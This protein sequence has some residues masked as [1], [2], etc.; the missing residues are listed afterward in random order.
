MA[1]L[2]N[3]LKLG[4][5]GAILF[6]LVISPYSKVEESFNLQAIH[7]ILNYG[8][9]IEKYD[10]LEF[11]GVVP[12]TFIGGLLVSSLV[13]PFVKYFNLATGKQLS[14]QFL[15]RLVIGVANG[16]LLIR[17]GDAIKRIDFQARRQ[18]RSSYMGTCFLFLLLS[19]FHIL[20]YASRTLP[21]FMALPFVNLGLAKLIEGDTRGLTWLAITGLIFR[22]EVAVFAGVIALVSSVG[23][24]QSD[25]FINVLLLAVGSIFGAVVSGVI[26]TQFWREFVV[27]ELWSLK[28]NVVDGKASNWGTEPYN[29]YFSKYLF[30]IFRPPI[31]LIL[32][33]VGL[34]LDPTDDGLVVLD[35]KRKQVSRPCRN[36]L[37]ILFTS[38]ILYIGIM[39]LQP[40]KEWRFIIYTVPV[41]TVVAANGLASFLDRSFLS[42]SRKVL[43]FIF[44]VLTILASIISVF[45][46]YISSYNYPGGT[47]MQIANDL[48]LSLEKPVKIHLD[49]PTCM[50]GA[51]RFGE[52][53]NDSIVYDKTET[54][55][56]LQSVWNTI[57]ILVT[58]EKVEADEWE[59]VSSVSSF[60]GI[61]IYPYI[62]ISKQNPTPYK[63]FLFVANTLVD[64]VKNRE[65]LDVKALI[66][67]PIMNADY[68]FI[69]KRLYKAQAEEIPIEED[70]NHEM[71]DEPDLSSVA[72]EINLQIDDIET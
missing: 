65:F 47:A 25:L 6:H 13:T 57:D 46:G 41:F 26:D 9:S 30:Q 42:W 38:S 17:L 8:F 45:M 35:E 68:L 11:P 23:F 4:V 64:A 1:V 32:S 52:L 70:V 20:Y 48:A 37:R 7:D 72:Q 55:D 71:V 58:H 27:P 28:Y 22:L 14:L 66:D 5:I 3:I 60:A 2:E 44:V 29:A 36:S 61:S 31:V 21:N 59:L 15:I 50:T 19:Q 40:H 69:Y 10:H 34:L 49:V 62:I 18:K 39:S 53:H 63:L 54:A 43:C 24:G 67:A 51:S 56:A 33:V 16:V 12:R